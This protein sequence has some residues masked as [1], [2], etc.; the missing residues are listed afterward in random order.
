MVILFLLQWKR[1]NK[2]QPWSWFNKYNGV[3]LK[4]NGNELILRFIC[5]CKVAILYV[6]SNFY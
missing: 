4:S 2:W 3:N 1:K 5:N 6:N